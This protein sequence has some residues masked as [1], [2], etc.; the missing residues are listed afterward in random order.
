M[1]VTVG[2]NKGTSLLECFTAE[3]IRTHLWML[4]NPTVPPPLNSMW[5]G[6][7]GDGVDVDGGLLGVQGVWLWREGCLM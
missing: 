1:R 4:L 5:R 3:E 2:D 7:G 6:M